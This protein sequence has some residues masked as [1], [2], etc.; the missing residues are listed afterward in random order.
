MEAQRRFYAECRR[1]REELEAA[2][3]HGRARAGR[4]AGSRTRS[5]QD[6]LER[7]EQL[8]KERR[9]EAILRQ[10]R[11]GAEAGGRD[12]GRAGVGGGGSAVVRLVGRRASAPK[13]APGA[14]G[15]PRAGGVDGLGGVVS[16]CCCS[17]ACCRCRRRRR[18]GRALVA[19]ADRNIGLVGWWAT[20]ALTPVV[21]GPCLLLAV[22]AEWR[23]VA[24]SAGCSAGAGPVEIDG[25]DAG[26][27]GIVWVV[28][29]PATA[30]EKCRDATRR[31][32]GMHVQAV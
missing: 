16:A 29:A 4:T 7:N 6:L 25:P 17:S 13:A 28:T 19:G 5:L 21:C 11:V 12:G 8:A 18:P 27:A 20:G 32:G 15:R 23:L 31:P 14:G 30:R 9:F 1:A 26:A 10:G 24:A 3:G 2:A 22:V